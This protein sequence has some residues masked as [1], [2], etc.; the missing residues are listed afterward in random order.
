MAIMHAE[1]LELNDRLIHHLNEKSTQLRRVVGLC[2]T[3]VPQVT[4]L[5]NY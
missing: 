5:I 2:K 1:L 4:H 3:Y